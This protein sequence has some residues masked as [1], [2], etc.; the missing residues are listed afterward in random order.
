MCNFLAN[1]VYVDG[2]GESSAITLNINGQ[3][4]IVYGISIILLIL[5]GSAMTL[6]K[7]SSLSILMCRNIEMR[8]ITN[9]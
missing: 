4:V 6:K 3:C 8:I 7:S 1:S 5:E 9:K 2:D